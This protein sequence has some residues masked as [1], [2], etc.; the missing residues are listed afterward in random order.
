MTNQIIIDSNRGKFLFTR[1]FEEIKEYLSDEQKDSLYFCYYDRE[2]TTTEFVNKLSECGVE[3][4]QIYRTLKNKQTFAIDDKRQ[5][6]REMVGCRCVPRSYLLYKDFDKARENYA[7]DKIWFIKSRGGTG[8]RGVSCQTTKEL[9]QDP[10]VEY[11]IQEEITPIDLWQNR[12]YVIRSY[13]LVWNKQVWFHKKALAF[14][15][16]ADYSTA[17]CDHNVQVSHAGY[18]S[19][20]GAVKV[21][22]L[23]NIMDLKDHPLNFH[24]I[25]LHEMYDV[26]KVIAE[27]FDKMVQASNEREYILLGVDYLPIKKP[28]NNYSVKIVEVN[29]YPNICH[30]DITNRHVNERVIRDTM[31]VLFGLNDTLGHD[32]VSV[33]TK[34][35]D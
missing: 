19:E 12:K 35:K 21:H 20:S 22:S 17:N 6:V 9:V 26:T 33:P 29:R 23:E 31:Y 7:D 1:A 15:H 32:Y 13:I 2:N 5:F 25:L 14:V 27:R 3:A 18:H 24:N 30:T 4:T 16:G 34:C 10:G 8:G 11:V 28:N